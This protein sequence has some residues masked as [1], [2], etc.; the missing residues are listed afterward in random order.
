MTYLQRNERFGGHTKGERQVVGDGNDT[1]ST[2]TMHNL[3]LTMKL[4]GQLFSF[5]VNMGKAMESSMEKI[6]KLQP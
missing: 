1:T 6:F 2:C 3:A 5:T 4:E